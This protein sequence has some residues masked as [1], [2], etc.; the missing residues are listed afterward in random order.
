MLYHLLFVAAVGSVS[1]LPAEPTL[2]ARGPINCAKVDGAIA[3]LKNLGTP[4]TTFCSSFLK[5]PAIATA[6]ATIIPTRTI[7]I[8]TVTVTT[9]SSV[10]PAPAEDPSPQAITMVKKKA[11]EAEAEPVVNL[12][13]L[14]IAFADAKISA[15]CCCLNIKPR[16]TTTATVTAAPSRTNI[17]STTTSCVNPDPVVLTIPVN[18][19]CADGPAPCAQG[20]SCCQAPD[21]DDVYRARCRVD[22]CQK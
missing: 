11:R 16:A 8:S 22:G 21:P 6:T 12:L 13:P 19:L 1:A 7:V 14:L 15:G 18:G 3:V 10:C 4:A 5:I 17:I 9:F 20:S 2:A